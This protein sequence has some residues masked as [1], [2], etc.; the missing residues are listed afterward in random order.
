MKVLLVLII[1]S[2]VLATYPPHEA[3]AGTQQVNNLKDSVSHLRQFAD[4]QYMCNNDK[5]L[6]LKLL[7]LQ[8]TVKEI[9]H[10]KK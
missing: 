4:S 9:I 6:E 8:L 1:A 5:M 3:R 10:T 7:T 2:I